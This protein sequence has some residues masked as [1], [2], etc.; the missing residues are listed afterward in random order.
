MRQGNYFVTKATTKN[1]ESI[2]VLLYFI[3]FRVLCGVPCMEQASHGAGTGQTWQQEILCVRRT[4]NNRTT[5][6]RP[7]GLI[8]V[9]RRMPRMCSM[10][11]FSPVNV[12]RWRTLISNRFLFSSNFFFF[13]SFSFFHFEFIVMYK[14]ILLKFYAY[15]HG[16]HGRIDN[17]QACLNNNFIL[18][19]INCK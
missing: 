14:M 4:Q 18:T 2:F 16:A 1:E 17:C 7:N 3:W 9:C 12:G 10:W 6:P 8:A 13:W 15:K 11:V 19:R 5:R